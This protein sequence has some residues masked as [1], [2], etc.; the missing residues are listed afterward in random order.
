MADDREGDVDG[1][2]DGAPLLDASAGFLLRAGSRQ[3]SRHVLR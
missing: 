3:R 2:A 1:A